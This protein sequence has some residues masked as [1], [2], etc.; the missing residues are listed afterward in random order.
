M[1]DTQFLQLTD[2][3]P[4]GRTVAEIERK[5]TKQSGRGRV[6][7]LV[8]AKAD[9]GT[10]AAWKSDLNRIL[11]V[12]NVRSNVITWTLLTA[13]FQTEL[14]MNTNITVSD[15][16]HDVSKIREEISGQVR[17]VT[18]SHIQPTNSRRILTVA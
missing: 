14:A 5:I 12:F 8:H 15:M 9:G 4:D 7:R 17:S 11:H 18:V 16:R 2:G 10:I 13:P 3:A 1:G 6:S